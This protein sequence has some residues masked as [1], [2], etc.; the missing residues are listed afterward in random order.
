MRCSITLSTPVQSIEYVAPRSNFQDPNGQS[1]M[2]TLIVMSSTSG[3]LG[4]IAGNPAN[5][6]NVRM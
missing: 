3:F 2:A 5:V 6:L 4:G 1:S